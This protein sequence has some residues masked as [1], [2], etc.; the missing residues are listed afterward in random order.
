MINNTEHQYEESQIV[1]FAEGL[2]GLPQMRR[3]ALI[4]AEGFAP[5]SWLASLDDDSVR[6]I[7][8][9]PK[10]VFAD[11]DSGSELSTLAIVKISS[12][13]QK[14]T[15]NLRAPIFVDTKT[16]RGSQVILSESNYKL[17]EA[18]PLN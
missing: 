3:A 18:L 7:V 9:D 4:P 14:T 1:E 15:V 6:F 8:V 2:L 12:D 10:E 5:F 16:K 17:E 11:Y 13:W